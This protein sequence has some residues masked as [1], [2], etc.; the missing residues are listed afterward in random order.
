M[1]LYEDHCSN[2][3]QTVL[4]GIFS[5]PDGPWSHTTTATQ[6]RSTDTDF[7]Q[8]WKSFSY[9]QCVQRTFLCGHSCIPMWP[10]LHLQKQFLLTIQ[11]S[12]LCTVWSILLQEWTRDIFGT[13]ALSVHWSV[14]SSS[15]PGEFAGLLKLPWRAAVKTGQM[16]HSE[17]S[18]SA[19][20]LVTH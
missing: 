1:G 5:Y 20:H 9:L 14:H 15:C 18:S 12:C 4:M 3:L 13:A 10:F 2:I 6:A 8:L 16:L 7:L 17:A 19:E 11:V